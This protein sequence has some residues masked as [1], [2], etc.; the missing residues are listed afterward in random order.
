MKKSALFIFIVGLLSINGFGQGN[1]EEYLSLP[2]SGKLIYTPPLSFTNIVTSKSDT[3][4]VGMDGIDPG[5]GNPSFLINL[6]KL[7]SDKVGIGPLTNPVAT[8][9]VGGNGLISKQLTVGH[10]LAIDPNLQ[11]LKMKIGDAWTFSDLSSGKIMGYNCQFSASGSAERYLEGNT[12]AAAVKLN[13]DGSVQLC[14]APDNAQEAPLTWNYLTMLNDGNVGIGTP[15]PEKKL[16]VHGDSYMDGKVGIGTT[17][18]EYNLDV[19]GDINA[20]KVHTNNIYFHETDMRI[21]SV[22]DGIIM[23]P[24][25][26]IEE[27]QGEGEDEGEDD[28]SEEFRPTYKNIVI[29][30]SDGKVGIGAEPQKK[31]HVEGESYMSGK[32]GLGTTRPE[33]K[34][35]V[36]GTGCFSSNLGIGIT[37]PEKRLH[38]VGDS[39]FNGKVGIGISDPQKTFH[40][41]GD[42]Y[43]SGNV[44]IGTKDTQGYKLAVKGVIGAEKVKLEKTTNWADYVFEPDYN[45]MSISDLET[46]INENKHLPNIPNKEEVYKNGQDIGEINRLLLEKI[47]ELTLY[48]IQ[49]QKEIDELK[50]R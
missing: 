13:T 16:H 23:P 12:A 6:L 25:K 36:I 20:N 31:F 21:V 33:Q 8:L 28:G 38:V 46:F 29:F 11:S 39:Y 18:P 47:E 42:T 3:L 37:T 30:K 7:T 19:D 44:G 50:K 26:E 17:N 5:G 27:E 43:L 2:L 1:G 10:N 34:L 9:H 14:T 4:D 45:L 49:Q 24:D 40:V 35:H 41:Q 15:N 32:L 48:I 22:T